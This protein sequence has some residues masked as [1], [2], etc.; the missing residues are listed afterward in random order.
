MLKGRNK[1][2]TLKKNLVIGQL[3]LVGDSEDISGRG[4]Y[5]LGKVHR[6]Y[7]QIQQGQEV[8]RRA[9]VAIL[10]KAPG[11]LQYVLRDLAKIAPV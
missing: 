9:T 6:L 8:V 3:V 1:W 10:G 5:R 7:P 2:R 4:A 11:E